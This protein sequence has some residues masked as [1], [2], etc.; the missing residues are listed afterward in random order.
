MQTRVGWVAR[1]SLPDATRS[2]RVYPL[3]QNLDLENLAFATL[4]GTGE[5]LNIEE[6]NE[7]ELRRLVL[8]NLARLTVKGE[9]DGLLTAGGGGGI[10][11]P[12]IGTTNETQYIVSKS[13][14]W[15]H[16]DTGADIP[17][18]SLNKCIAWPF[19]SPVSGTVSAQ[20]IQVSAAGGSETTLYAAIYAENDAKL[21]GTLLG[22][23][24]H[25]TTSTGTKTQTSFSSSI[26]LVAGT[27]YWYTINMGGSGSSTQLQGSI[28][29]TP[30]IGIGSS[31]TESGA[32]VFD[33]NMTAYAVPPAT[34]VASYVY[35]GI[36]RPILTLA[37]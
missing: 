6:M 11:L 3:L 34:F 15:G 2:D 12:T 1:M 31:P 35:S 22:Y 8:I 18:T 36:G 19:I 10:S 13:P 9:W 26:T 5:T 32:A 28:N 17:F 7:D 20:S 37:F 33:N 23:A 29:S 30:N 21:P 16:N 14:I 24:T 25:D 4:Q 27:T